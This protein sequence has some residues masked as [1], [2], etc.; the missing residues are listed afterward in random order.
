M[1]SLELDSNRIKPVD[2]K[3]VCVQAFDHRTG[4][5]DRVVSTLPCSCI[6]KQFL[7]SFGQMT[8]TN[9]CYSNVVGI[10]AC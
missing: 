3:A 1:F 4:L 6:K 10:E 2:V 5:E 9:K 8:R 7:D